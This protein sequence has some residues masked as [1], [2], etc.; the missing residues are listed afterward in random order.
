MIVLKGFI[1]ETPVEFDG[2]IFGGQSDILYAKTAEEMIDVM[3][4]AEMFPLKAGEKL[5]IE[6]V[7]MSEEEFAL[8]PDYNG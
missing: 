4:S 2:N 7:E 6:A 8:I 3:T 1:E 5:V